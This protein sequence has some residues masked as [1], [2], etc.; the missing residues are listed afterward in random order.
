MPQKLDN[1]RQRQSKRKVIIGL[2]VAAVLIAAF[3]IGLYMFENVWENNDDD[4]EFSDDDIVLYIGDK[5]YKITH[6]VET[7][8]MIGTDDSGDVEKE[9]TEDYH[10]QMAD[11]LLL[12][13]ID[14]TDETYGFLQIDR[15]T[16]VDVPLVDTEGNGED[17]ELQQ[18]CT[19]HWYGGN[20]EHSNNNTVYCVGELLGGLPIDGYYEIHM[21][22]IGILN[23]AVGGV[24]VTLNEDFSAA[25]PEMTKGKTLTLNDKQAEIFVRGR[26]E[27]GDGTNEARMARQQQYMNAFKAKAKAELSE[28]SSFINKLYDDLD[29]VSLTTIQENQLSVIANQ[30]YKGTDLGFVTLDGKTVIGTTLQDGKEHE[31]FYPEEESIANAMVKLCGIE[32]TQIHDYVD[33][34]EF[35]DEDEAED[36][37]GEDE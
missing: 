35:E 14:R 11:F 9:N 18:I 4:L 26:M 7:Y 27:V 16:M 31:E 33:D 8:L 3:G 32:K 20:R 36:D 10:G 28:D 15:N 23:H 12:F 22:D 5:V 25:D 37:T 17:T 1:M 24:E 6:N 2:A 21:S 13:V 29:A 19:A 30:M 34:E